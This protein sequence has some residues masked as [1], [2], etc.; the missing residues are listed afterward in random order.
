M[1]L[2]QVQIL[3]Q[4]RKAASSKRQA[5]SSAK[6][7]DSSDKMDSSSEK[8]KVVPKNMNQDKI[9]A[10]HLDEKEKLFRPE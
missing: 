8:E 2:S 10:N 6:R 4:R 3:L 5:A 7:N 9:P 1:K